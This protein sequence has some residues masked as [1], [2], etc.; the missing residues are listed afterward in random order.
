MNFWQKIGL[1]LLIGGALYWGYKNYCPLC[2]T[3]AP[4]ATQPAA[5]A[6]AR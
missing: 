1:L 2:R 6:P 3:P 4:S 5:T